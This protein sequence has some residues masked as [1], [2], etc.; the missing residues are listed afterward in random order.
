MAPQNAQQSQPNTDPLTLP[1]VDIFCQKQRK[2]LGIRPVC[3]RTNGK[4]PLCQGCPHN[5]QSNWGQ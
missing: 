2:G 3:T 5:I 1:E 4:K